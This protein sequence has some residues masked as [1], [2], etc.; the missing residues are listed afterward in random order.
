MSIDCHISLATLN[1]F[2]YLAFIGPVKDRVLVSTIL[3]LNSYDTR[4]I[5]DQMYIRLN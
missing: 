3:E 1:S 4:S 5:I 2:L